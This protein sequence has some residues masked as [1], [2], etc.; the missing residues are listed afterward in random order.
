MALHLGPEDNVLE[1]GPGMGALTEPLL[2]IMP[3]MRAIEIDRDLYAHLQ[4]ME[5]SALKLHL[6]L[7]DALALDYRQFGEHLRIIGNLPYNIST[8]LLFHLLTFASQ[9]DD[10]HFMLQKEV[11]LRLASQPGSKNYGRLSVMVQYHCE[12]EHLFDVPPE[13]FYPAPK[14]D[15]AFLRLSPYRQSPWPKVD[16]GALE[17][18]LSVA[19]AMRRKTLANNLKPL[20]T[21]VKIEALGIDP[22]QRPEQISVLDYVRM[23]N[24]LSEDTIK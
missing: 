1:I 14:V 23:A 18:L 17:K 21:A 15:S 19:F 24:F 13:S 11:V 9:I 12:V 22:K 3:K 6:I 2:K 20:L 8:P 5:P 7:A 10:M 16:L 4:R